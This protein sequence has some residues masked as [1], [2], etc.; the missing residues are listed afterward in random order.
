MSEETTTLVLDD[1][2]HFAGMFVSGI[3]AYVEGFVGYYLY[4]SFGDWLA[5]LIVLFIVQTYVFGALISYRKWGQT[6]PPLTMA[7]RE[8]KQNE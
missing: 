1:G 4:G 3:V 7:E 8:E 2:P 6:V 5:W